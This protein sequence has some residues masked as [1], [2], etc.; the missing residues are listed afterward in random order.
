MYHP[1]TQRTFK[2]FLRTLAGAVLCGMIAIPQQ[3]KA[4]PE[5]G[6]LY[7]Y[8][9]EARVLKLSAPIGKAAIGNGKVLSTA[10][11]A[12]TELLMIANDAGESSLYLW[13]KDGTEIHYT[14]QVGANNPA[15]TF[16]QIKRFFDDDKNIKTSLIGDRVFLQGN[17]L[18]PEQQNRVDALL[19]AFPNQIVP[20]FGG[21]ANLQERTV[22]ISAQVVEIK[23]ST[24]ENLGIEWAE[25]FQGP[26]A[27]ILG[28]IKRNDLY[29]LR[30]DS[31]EF[32][33]INIDVS[34][35]Q[36]Y[37]GIA[38]SITSRINILQ[39]KGDAYIIA[40]PHL[41]ARCGGKAD[42]TSGGELPIPLPSGLGQTSVEYKP[43]GIRLAIEPIC[44][45]GGNI[46]A[47]LT[48]EVSQID[49]SVTVLGVPGLLSRKAESELDLIDG[50]AMLLSGLSSL[51]ASED[52]SQVPGLGSIPLFGNLF[53]NNN[54]GGERS[55]LVIIITPTF[56]TTDS[57]TVRQGIQRRD[58]ISSDIEEKLVEQGV[59][60]FSPA[61]PV[62]AEAAA[63]PSNIH[64][65]TPVAEN[66]KAA[67]QN[68]SVE[69]PVEPLSP[70]ITTEE[71]GQDDI[72]T[73][74]NTPSAPEHETTPS[75]LSN[76]HAPST[77]ASQEPPPAT[78]SPFALN[79]QIPGRVRV[80][81]KFTAVIQMKSALGLRNI[82]LLLGFDPKVLQV[83][84][85]QEGNF[86]KQDDFFKQGKG[87]MVFHYRLNASKPGKKSRKDL[88]LARLEQ[89]DDT[90]AKSMSGE[91]NLLIV[92]FKAISASKSTP[93]KLM[94]FASEPA[95][96]LADFTLPFEHTLKIVAR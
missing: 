51:R 47:K 74:G 17:N 55:E 35:F 33:N 82:S 80:G 9:G 34:P 10:T 29:R 59:K 38:S 73:P 22:F 79:W 65:D 57:A 31:G 4:A 42:F 3:I 54:F 50:K 76:D 93:L 12:P 18:T 13:L 14:V 23:K 88:I 21:D 56:V 30:G 84:S 63:S 2:K 83:V 37:L 27:G 89:L 8:V 6:S 45:K 91:G 68:S 75:A 44:D 5:E 69:Q 11:V 61:Q 87:K 90:L 48:A 26:T 32:A 62:A 7:L 64:D 25:Q 58:K 94:E 66:A 15:R 81:E 24:L 78:S 41:T 77:E 95:L 53:K 86:F 92:N 96:A 70:G 49:P 52:T 72:Q 67:P 19:K 36:T 43:Y 46:R 40:A 85:V 20:I 1:T 16:D 28:D 60:P 71:A 39:Q